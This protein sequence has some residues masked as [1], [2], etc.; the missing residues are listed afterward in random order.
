M[1]EFFYCTRLSQIYKRF[2]AKNNINMISS[3]TWSENMITSLLNLSKLVWGLPLILASLNA[4]LKI[5]FLNLCVF[6]SM[7]LL[8]NLFYLAHRIQQPISKLGSWIRT[9][10]FV[11]AKQISSEEKNTITNK[12]P[13]LQMFK[14]IVQIQIRSFGFACLIR[15]TTYTY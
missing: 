10:T 6:V 12:Q 15:W 2:S 1:Y 13:K 5:L 14:K 8:K 4:L 7:K 3:Q 11:L 9:Y